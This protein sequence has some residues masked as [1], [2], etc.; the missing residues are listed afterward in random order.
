MSPATSDK[1]VNT[2]LSGSEMKQ[3]ILAD[4]ERLLAND[5]SLTPYVAY[6]RGGWRIVFTLQTGNA[7][8]P[9]VTSTIEGGEKLPIE[10][11]I[12]TATELERTF[13]SPNE[14]RLRAGMPIPVRSKELDGTVVTKMVSYPADETLGEGK[15]TTKDV[16]EREA[17]KLRTI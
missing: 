5:G 16:S 12:T 10:D 2:A 4:F 6:G 8:T 17:K 3:L 7:R 11:A 9:E 1:V 13:D 15:V 14:E